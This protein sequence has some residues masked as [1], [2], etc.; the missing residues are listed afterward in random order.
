[1]GPVINKVAYDRVMGFIQSAKEDGARL[2]MGGK[3]PRN[4]PGTEG[5]FFIEPT[6][7]ADVKPHFKI[8]QEEHLCRAGLSGPNVISGSFVDNDVFVSSLLVFF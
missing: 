7:F 4:I 8:A 5:G 1:M 3:P 2:V 6:I